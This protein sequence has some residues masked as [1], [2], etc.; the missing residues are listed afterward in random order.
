MRRP[1]GLLAAAVLALVI[2]P[3]AHAAFGDRALQRGAHGH[4]VRVLQSWLTRAGWPTHV[5]GRYGRRTASNVRRFER[6]NGRPVDGRLSRGDARVL[7]A[8]VEAPTRSA[9]PVTGVAVLAP[10]GLTAVAPS[11]APPAV[12]AAIAAANGLV[13]KPYKWGGGHGRWEDSGYDCSG[14]VSFALH[15]AGLLDAALDSSQLA[16]WAEPGVGTW[17][18]VY[19]RTDHAYAV[20]AGLR[21]DTSGSGGAGPRWHTRQRSG[22]GYAARHPL[23]L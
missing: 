3:A 2:A 6:G 21:F 16:R 14:S 10:D 18:T 11:D 9:A 7:R 20:I 19:G 5:D 4:D 8:R 13:T 1:C 22:R 17:I 15:R 12:Q 23:S